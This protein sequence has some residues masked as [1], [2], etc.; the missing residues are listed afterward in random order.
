MAL[1]PKIIVFWYVTP[2]ISVECKQRFEGNAS[3]IMGKKEMLQG[4]FGT[5]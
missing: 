2:L 1:S 3:S 5:D 4:I